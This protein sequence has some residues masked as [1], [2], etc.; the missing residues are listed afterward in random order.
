MDGDK[1]TAKKKKE[2]LLA[3]KEAAAAVKKDPDNLELLEALNEANK[4]V[5]SITTEL[6]E[7]KGNTEIRWVTKSGFPVRYTAFTRRKDTC[8][9]TL[10]GLTKPNT[11]NTPV[12]G[13]FG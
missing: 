11:P 5:R 8:K 10:R 7:G 3:A 9:S 12:L 4:I 6:I 1:I 13:V 2:Y